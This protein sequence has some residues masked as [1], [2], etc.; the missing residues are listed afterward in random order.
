VLVV[1][2]PLGA[3]GAAFRRGE[4]PRPPLRLGEGRELGVHAHAMLDI[5]DGL[6][7]DA[8]HL[9]DRSGCR[10]EIELDRVRLA[11]GATIDDLGFG[12]DYELLAAVEDPGR[13]AAIG[14]CVSGAGTAFTLNGEPYELRGWEHFHNGKSAEPL[15]GGG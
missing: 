1:T 14:Q 2:G 8:A 15:A 5:S 9:A 7:V 13:F 6:A 4:L 12:E 11:P 10:I 3:A